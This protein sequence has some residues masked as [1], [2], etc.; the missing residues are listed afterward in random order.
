MLFLSHT[1]Q[2]GRHVLLLTGE[3][4]SDFQ[5]R[6]L[7]A[8]IQEPAG[9]SLEFFI[10]HHPLNTDPFPAGHSMHFESE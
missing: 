2:K 8:K 10:R 9:I 4:E 1:M 3:H 5:S 7:S 6:P